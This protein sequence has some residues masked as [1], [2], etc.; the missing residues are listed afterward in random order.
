VDQ[1]VGVIDSTV[2]HYLI[3]LLVLT[4]PSPSKVC[5]P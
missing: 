1:P 2:D 5:I 3:F 4:H